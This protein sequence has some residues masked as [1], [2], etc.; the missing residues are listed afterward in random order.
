MPIEIHGEDR[1]QYYNYKSF[2]SIHLKAV[3]IAD[4]RFTFVYTGF[5]GR[6]DN[7]Y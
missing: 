6:Y 7:F 1:Q 5:P 4:L 3:A 2:H